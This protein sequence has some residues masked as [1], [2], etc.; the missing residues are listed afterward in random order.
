VYQKISALLVILTLL[1]VQVLGFS[2]K[3]D[4]GGDAGCCSKHQVCLVQPLRI[5]EPNELF[6]HTKS[7]RDILFDF[8]LTARIMTLTAAVL[9]PEKGTSAI[10]FLAME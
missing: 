9:P 10:A 5:V 1:Q 6:T 7:A 2:M 8:G 3:P 4:G